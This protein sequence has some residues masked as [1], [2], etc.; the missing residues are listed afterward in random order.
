MF[1]VVML[2][3]LWVHA[4]NIITINEKGVSNGAL[5]AVWRNIGANHLH[6]SC[7]QLYAR[8]PNKWAG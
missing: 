6:F 2:A 5:F 7:A 3:S 8:L 4:S 1:S